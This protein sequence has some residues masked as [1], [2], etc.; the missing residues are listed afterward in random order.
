MNKTSI[1]WTDY[2]WNPI[3]ARRMVKMCDECKSPINPDGTC[4]KCR[5]GHG[6]PF[7]VDMQTLYLQPRTGTFCTRISPGCTNCYASVI[8]K[9]FGT[10]LEYT[11]PNLTEHEFFID[12][13]IL[14]QPLRYKKPSRIFVGDMFDLFHEAIPVW[15]ICAV[16]SVMQRSEQHTFQVL[17][18][19]AQRLRT[20]ATDATTI[21]HIEEIHPA[22][23]TKREGFC[24]W[25]LPNVWHGVSVEDKLRAH[26]RIPRL[27]ETPSAVRFLSIEPQLEEVPTG[28]SPDQVHG[29]SN[30]N[31]RNLCSPSAAPQKCHSS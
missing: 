11:V 15:M 3:R 4:P 2:T 25:P 21:Q 26:E 5:D 30:L 29:R 24:S 8:N 31:G 27:Q 16:Y 1:E 10:G 14:E 23:R 6:K 19:R 17:T 7:V 20:F 9:R 28:L 12:E 22:F 18:K 13:R